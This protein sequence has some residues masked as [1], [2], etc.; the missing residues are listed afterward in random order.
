MEVCLDQHLACQPLAV[1]LLA[2]ERLAVERLALE[3]LAIQQKPRVRWTVARVVS[4]IT[5]E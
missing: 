4:T 3:P 1:A 2:V 5:Y